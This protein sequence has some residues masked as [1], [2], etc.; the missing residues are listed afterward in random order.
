MVL[1]VAA[2]L[3]Q[4]QSFAP[5]VQSVGAQMPVIHAVSVNSLKSFKQSAPVSTHPP[6][7][8]E[9]DLITST[10]ESSSTHL[11]LDE[12]HL[13]NADSKNEF[14]SSLKTAAFETPD[15]AQSFSTVRIP[16]VSTKESKFREALS[17]PSRRQ[18]LALALLQHSA[19]VFDAY[20]TR[21]AVGH[22]A[23]EDNPMLR[24][25]AGSG[26]IYA[27]TQLTPLVLDLVARHMQRS[28]YPLLR[29]F[30]WMPQTVS[31]GLSIFSGVHNLS[32]AGKL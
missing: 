9:E 3:L 8:I 10:T 20:S 2:L 14:S 32:V 13:V 18:W 21:Q 6:F 1:A 27:A 23:V 25:F 28:E 12:V 7:A 16:E 31:A 29:R 22:G 19:A 4:F 17:Q 26:A 30:W 15:E 11:N 5:P 24:P